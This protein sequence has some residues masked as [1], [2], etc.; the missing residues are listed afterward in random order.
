MEL[1]S[2]CESFAIRE[3]RREIVILDQS[4]GS[5]GA[6]MPLD[7]RLCA[8]VNKEMPLCF[9]MG[10][11]GTS[12][13]VRRV[14]CWCAAVISSAW[15]VLAC[16]K[17][18]L[19]LPHRVRNDKRPPSPAT[20]HSRPSAETPRF[21]DVRPSSFSMGSKTDFALR[22]CKVTVIVVKPDSKLPEMHQPATILVGLRGSLLCAALVKRALWL[23][24]VPASATNDV[25]AFL[26]RA[27]SA[28]LSSV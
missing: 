22:N 17:E 14:W 24:C 10:I 26:W 13:Y 3:D 18:R 4:E 16:H 9:V 28:I 5:F 6:G 19:A 2:K 23:V 11:F 7:K 27:A 15:Y 8:Y 25:A 20:P 21:D 1:V 12:G